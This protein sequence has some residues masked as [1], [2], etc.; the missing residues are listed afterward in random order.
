MALIADR[1]GTGLGSLDLVDRTAV[2]DYAALA[3][4]ATVRGRAVAE[5]LAS[6]DPDAPAALRLIASAFDGREIVA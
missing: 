1:S 4:E 6:R 2:A 3:R 5:L